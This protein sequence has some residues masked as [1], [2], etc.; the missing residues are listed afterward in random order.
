MDFNANK[1]EEIHMGKRNLDFHDGWAKSADEER[2]LGVLMSRDL[3]FSNNVCW[4]KIKLI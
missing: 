4:Q 2:D 3:K 1:C